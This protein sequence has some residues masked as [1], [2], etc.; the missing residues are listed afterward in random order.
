MKT[1]FDWLLCGRFFRYYGYFYVKV[2][3]NSA[4]CFNLRKLRHF[5]SDS[6]VWRIKV[7]NIYGYD[8]EEFSTVW[9]GV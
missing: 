1:Q 7:T 5:R 2:S 6:K 9:S 8:K 4:Y 3:D